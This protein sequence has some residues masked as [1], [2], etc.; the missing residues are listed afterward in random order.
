VVPPLSPGQE[1]IESFESF[2]LSAAPC[3][4]VTCP[5]LP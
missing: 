5:S 1:S 3:P 2:V 4:V